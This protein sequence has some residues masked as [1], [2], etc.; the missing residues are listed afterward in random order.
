MQQCME[1]RREHGG[2]GSGAHKPLAD[3]VERLKFEV[4]DLHRHFLLFSR[5]T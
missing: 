3:S 2:A 5:H 4:I 1:N